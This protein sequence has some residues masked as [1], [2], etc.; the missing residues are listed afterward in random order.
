VDREERQGKLLLFFV[1][2]LGDLVDLDGGILM[3]KPFRFVQLG[4]PVYVYQLASLQ[5]EVTKELFEVKPERRFQRMYAPF[6]G[7]IYISF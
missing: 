6:L 7:Y 2:M 3:M 1:V 5:G 4:V